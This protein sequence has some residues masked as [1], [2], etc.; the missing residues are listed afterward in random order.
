MSDASA[1]LRASELDAHSARDNR[2]LV[3]GVTWEQYE[4]LSEILADRPGLRLTY[5]EGTLELMSPSRPHERQKSMLGRLLET[6]AVETRTPLAAY[7]S[8]TYRKRA[9]ERGAEPDEC[10]VVGRSLDDDRED[11][12]PDLVVEVIWTHGGLDKL[13]VYSGLRVPELWLFRGGRIEVYRLRG[14][15]YERC[16]RS[17]LLP[18]LDLELLGRFVDRRDQTEAVI[19]YQGA[20]L[21]TAER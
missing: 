3:G 9:N 11:D 14:S 13:D 7:G 5:V 2:I 20:L 18:A 15:A 19:E 12:R 6:W 21:G 10:Y 4:A 17:E 8:A 16:T 1:A